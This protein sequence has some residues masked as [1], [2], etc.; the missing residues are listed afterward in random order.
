MIVAF[1]MSNGTL[2]GTHTVQG[3]VQ[4]PYNG[5]S[6]ETNTFNVDTE[7]YLMFLMV[8]NGIQ[9][10]DFYKIFYYSNYITETH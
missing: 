8:L 10:G 2:N 6:M 5:I 7:R 9:L 4:I 1:P 3:T